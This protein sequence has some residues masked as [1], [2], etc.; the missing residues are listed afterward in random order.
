MEYGA[1]LCQQNAEKKP[2]FEE[3]F[4][5]LFYGKGL[6][7]FLLRC[8]ITKWKDFILPKKAHT[9]RKKNKNLPKEN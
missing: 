5:S 3:S 1:A 4:L 6:E 7:S 8:Y 9:E 2:V